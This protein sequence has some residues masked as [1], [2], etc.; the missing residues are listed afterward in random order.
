MP[1][2]TQPVKA[3]CPENMKC[4]PEDDAEQPAFKKRGVTSH[5]ILLTGSVGEV[6]G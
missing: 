2:V 1:A 4:V 5:S 3:I 6:G